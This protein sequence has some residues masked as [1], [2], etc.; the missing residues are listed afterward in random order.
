[1]P[2]GAEQSCEEGWPQ[3]GGGGLPSVPG[4]K[5]GGGDRSGVGK[6]WVPG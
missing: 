1:M 2:G 4:M 5:G 3:E 6:L